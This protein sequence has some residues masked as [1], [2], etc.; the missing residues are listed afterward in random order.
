MSFVHLRC[1]PECLLR[2]QVSGISQDAESFVI[3][4]APDLI[5]D[6]EWVKIAKGNVCTPKG[7]KA[8]GE[9]SLGYPRDLGFG[10][11]PRAPDATIDGLRQT[12]VTSGLS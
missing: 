6:G 10:Y 7:F 9:Q 2:F 8:T 5:P 4:A 1:N 11:P 12:H 3:P